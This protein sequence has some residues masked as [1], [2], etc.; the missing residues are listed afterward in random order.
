M[1]TNNEYRK[2]RGTNHP[3]TATPA[4]AEAAWYAANKEQIDARRARDAKRNGGKRTPWAKF[5]VN[6][7]TED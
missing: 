1:V 2:D 6:D 4:E 3:F 5:I 7:A